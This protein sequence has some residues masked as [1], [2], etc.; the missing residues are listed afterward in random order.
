MS[1]PGFG[2]HPDDDS[3][4]PLSQRAADGKFQPLI[5]TATEN[6][7]N[8]QGER[9]ARL[10]KEALLYYL[11]AA[12]T[13]AIP[14]IALVIWLGLNADKYTA[15]GWSSIHGAAIGGRLTQAEAKAIDFFSSAFIAPLILAAFNYIWFSCARVAAVNEF[16]ARK[17]GV[18][19][20]SLVEASSTTGGSYDILKLRVFLSA[21]TRRLMCLGFLVFFSGL[22]KSALGNVIAYEA[23]TETAAG[24]S[25]PLRLLSD[26]VIAAST[27]FAS[28]TFSGTYDY[29]VQQ[30]A[31][32]AN[33]FTGMM[34]GVSLQNARSKLDNQTYV[35]V[36][37]TAASLNSLPQ[38]VLELQDVPGRRWSVECSNWRPDIFSV[39]QTGVRTVTMSMTRGQNDLMTGMYPGD[40][41]TLQDA[42]NNVYPFMAF[43]FTGS[44]AYLGYLT[45]FNLSDDR[46]DSPYGTITP[47]AVNMTAFGFN[48]T[49]Q[50]MS[51]WGIYCW[52][53]QQNGSL[54]LSRAPD[55]SWSVNSSQWIDKKS[56]VQSLRLQQLQLSLNYNAPDVT[57]PGLGP[58][59]AGSATE[60]A[61]DSTGTDSPDYKTLAL[62]FLYASGEAER[63]A[64]EVAATNSS[65]SQPDF[66]YNVTTVEDVLHYRMTYVPLIL[67]IGLASLLV[68]AIITGGMVLY[69]WTSFSGRIFRQ[70]DVSRLLVDCMA[71][72]KD[73]DQYET[74]RSGSND[75]IE[76]WTRSY[77][78]RY[79]ESYGEGDPKVILQHVE[80]I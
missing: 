38:S 20:A 42:Y 6:T 64:Y 72:L 61:T 68:A 71:A 35:M 46:Y 36:N 5:G 15:R 54:H 34:T 43:N 26:S 21:R 47:L 23:F 53:H 19:L 44:A 27:P 33:E 60:A 52:I 73:R 62:N 22:A 2:F 39:S 63:I 70:V 9:Q 77:R 16:R 48:G 7:Y 50:I 58:A 69:T 40:I 49:K 65:R 8:Q 59:L 17:D 31:T 3:S 67:W 10:S 14:I 1:S 24:Q 13:V 28:S 51:V 12:L 78:V 57:I 37:A 30:Q 18:P 56:Q 25:P 41:G 4:V 76:D 29:S 32:F 75:E 79:S 45:S 74:A 66:F 11:A 80:L 55:G